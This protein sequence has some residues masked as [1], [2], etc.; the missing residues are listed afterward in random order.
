VSWPREAIPAIGRTFSYLTPST[1][2]L[3]GANRAVRLEADFADLR[4]EFLNLAVLVVA[5]GL[6][7]F[8]LT[9]WRDRQGQR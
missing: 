2:L 5:W 8:L 3:V 6:A 9:R 7:A 4:P 1:P